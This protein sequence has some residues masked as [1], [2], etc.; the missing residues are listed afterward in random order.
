[1]RPHELIPIALVGLALILG[2]YA[3]IETH[4]LT[5]GLYLINAIAIAFYDRPHNPEDPTP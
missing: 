1:M 3:V 5:A 2:T 4:Y